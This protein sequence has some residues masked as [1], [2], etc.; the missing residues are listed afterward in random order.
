MKKIFI[1]IMAVIGLAACSSRPTAVQS[2]TQSVVF[3]ADSA[4]HYIEHQVSLGARVPG[5]DA[6][7]QCILY[8]I[9]HLR[10]C[11]L[12]INL[13]QGTMINYAG[14][15]QA[16]Y[17]VLARLTTPQIESRKHILLCAHYD[18]RPWC[19]EEEI[20][21]NRYLPVPAANDGASG[22]GVL[23][24]I[25]RVLSDST[26]RA[27]LTQPID[28]VFF[29]CEDMG[30]PSFYTGVQRE[31]T[32]CLGSQMWASETVRQGNQNLYQYGI[33]LDM[34]GAPDAIFPKEYYSMQNGGDYVEKVWR[35][36]NELGY[37][38]YFQQQ[39][40][41]PITDDHYYVS[42]LGGIPCI[43]IIHYDARQNTGFPS[44]WHT[45]E[46][47]MRNID[48]AT[49]QAVGSTLLAVIK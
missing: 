45:L 19:D 12:Q 28:F 40:A 48:K 35:V 23:M 2:E 7:S 18:S 47:N 42:L 24:E 46:D 34:V 16:V 11:G 5:S 4:F 32:W 33:L 31:D 37:G 21:E 39:H 8:I 25:I 26:A 1:L 15:P 6:H 10:A 44:W 9:N 41:L 27:N 20:Y 43:D 22:V 17:N 13:Q 14:K 36:G 30:T 3:N 38:R 29:D 49:L